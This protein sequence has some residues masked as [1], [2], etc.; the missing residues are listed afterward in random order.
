[1]ITTG[2]PGGDQQNRRGPWLTLNAGLLFPLAA[3][4]ASGGVVDNLKSRGFSRFERP[5][6]PWSCAPAVYRLLHSLH[7]VRLFTALSS[8]ATSGGGPGMVIFDGGDAP[9]Q[10][11][12]A[13]LP[14]TRLRLELFRDGVHVHPQSHLIDSRRAVGDRPGC[15]GPRTAN[16]RFSPSAWAFPR[17]IRCCVSAARAAVRRR[18][19]PKRN[20]ARVLPARPGRK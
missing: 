9:A 3:G 6:K 10:K 14:V 16:D 13:D 5:A 11:V 4:A 1:V 8:G 18:R 19:P 12:E 15:A 17:P 7:Q 20:P 2:P